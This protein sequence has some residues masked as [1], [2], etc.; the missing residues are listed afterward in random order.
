MSTSRERL[1]ELLDRLE[2][3]RK[4]IPLIVVLLAVLEAGLTLYA[5]PGEGSA[6]FTAPPAPY[7]QDYSAGYSFDFGRGSYVVTLHPAGISVNATISC[8]LCNPGGSG[9]TI[10][11]RN[12][13]HERTITIRC[14]GGVY[15]TVNAVIPP[16]HEH[17]AD[18]VV[19]RVGP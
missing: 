10:T 15:V 13:T 5:W 7:L 4:A 14:D 9:N 6:S 8:L 16:F 3:V 19:R 18:V 2:A 11:L 1:Y 12:L 17:V